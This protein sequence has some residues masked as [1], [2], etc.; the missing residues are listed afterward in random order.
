MLSDR[1]VKS[2]SKKPNPV[3]EHNKHKW[4]HFKGPY[5]PNRQKQTDGQPVLSES[6][7]SPSLSSLQNHDTST[8]VPAC[9]LRSTLAAIVVDV[10]ERRHQ[11]G[12]ATKTATETQESGPS[13]INIVSLLLT[14][15]NHARTC[16]CDE[17]HLLR[18]RARYSLHTSHLAL[19]ADRTIHRARGGLKRVQRRS[20]RVSTRMP[21][22]CIVHL[23][24]MHLLWD[25][26][27]RVCLRI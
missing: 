25:R 19:P 5:K 7:P 1:S 23:R 24:R 26:L 18:S 2:N 15:P 16:R 22:G 4:Y 6:D 14:T 3:F 9:K 17:D 21:V 8:V 12:N 13:T 11:V 10:L 27:S 20:C